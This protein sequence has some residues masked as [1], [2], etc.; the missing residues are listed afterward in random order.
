MNI[1]PNGLVAVTRTDCRICHSRD[2]HPILDLGTPCLSDFPKPEDPPLPKV[3]LILVQCDSCGLVQLSQTVNPNLLYRQTYWYRS[4]INE[5]M[6]LEL[7]H[8]MLKAVEIVGGLTQNDVVV[9]VGAN[10]GTG[11]SM[12]RQVV[13]L[14]SQPFRIA[15]EPAVD[16]IEKLA[17]HADSIY[18]DFF[19]SM[20]SL[21]L[22][23]K[24]VKILTSIA[25]FYDLDDPLTFVQEVDRLLTDDGVWIVQMQDLAQMIEKT[26]YDN[27][28]FEHLCY[29]SLQTFNVLLSGSDLWVSHAEQR[30]INGGSLRIVVRRRQR[31]QVYP[32]DL[33][34][35]ERPW[36]TD[37]A[38]RQ[39]AWRVEQH[40]QHLQS[41]I[42]PHTYNG[43]VVDLYAASTK[44][45]TLLQYCGLDYRVVRQAV[46]R[47]PEKF[48][49]VTAGTNIPI[50][51]EE[52]W[53]ADP[54]PLTIVGAWAFRAAFLRREAG[55]LAGGGSFLFPLPFV[56]VVR[57]V[58]F[59]P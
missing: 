27:V 15:F 10:D 7:G 37:Q 30:S 9:D 16:M 33:Q 57:A 18:N 20:A 36:L 34:I 12:Y 25:M 1:Q 6:A 8:I 50:V 19:P 55:Y 32:M 5:A 58:R 45:N 46:E 31:A 2:L 23:D 53:R 11:L 42:E 56:E 54:A 41:V 39:F 59:V 38:L 40:K 35:V 26:A 3:P 14:N 13:P 52:A 29:Y 43:G 44:A 51:S 48:G 24:S 17:P 47:T 28:C 21:A 49:R 22:P 4:G